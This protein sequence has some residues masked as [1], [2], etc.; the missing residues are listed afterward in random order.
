M[1]R[2]IPALLCR[3]GGARIRRRGVHCHRCPSPGRGVPRR[4]IP[5]R[6]C[7]EH[8]RHSPPGLRHLHRGNPTAGPGPPDRTTRMRPRWAGSANSRTPPDSHTCAPANTTPLPASSR[9]T[10]PRPPASPEATGVLSLNGLVNI[11]YRRSDHGQG[12]RQGQK[13]AHRCSRRLGEGQERP[14]TVVLLADVITVSVGT[15]ASGATSSGTVNTASTMVWS[16]TAAVTNLTGAT[17]EADK[18]R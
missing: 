4:R 5:R 2:K 16:P 13:V 14:H 15:V 9:L 1:T 7:R 17:P 12:R 3:P 18:Q 8:H 11:Q 6:R 10:P